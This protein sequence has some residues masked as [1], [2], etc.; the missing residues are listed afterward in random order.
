MSYSNGISGLQRALSSIATTG[1]TQTNT[2]AATT[3]PNDAL[4]ASAE[5]TDQARLSSTGGLVAQ[6][7]E[8]SDVRV[9]KVA[10]L[11]QA[12]AS[13]SYSVS[14]SDVADKMINSLLE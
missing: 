8:G 14:A 3:K 5:Q 10:T 6:A 4:P 7:L 13:G 12:I 1:T 11:Q 9:D 2:P